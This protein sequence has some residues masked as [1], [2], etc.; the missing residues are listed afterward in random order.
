VDQVVAE[1]R[2][3]VSEEPLYLTVSLLLAV[4]AA[5]VEAPLTVH[6]QVPV[7]VA[8][9]VLLLTVMAVVA[10]P[11]AQVAE[12]VVVLGELQEAMEPVEQERV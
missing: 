4:A 12:P 3:C 5:V 8:A 7:A 6:M 11:V 1:L 9:C 10:E 2:M